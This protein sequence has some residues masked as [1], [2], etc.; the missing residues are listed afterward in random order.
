M[1]NQTQ[2]LKGSHLIITFKLI[3]ISHIDIDEVEKIEK[4]KTISIKAPN[5]IID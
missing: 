5:H 2:S 3:Q 4:F 1:A